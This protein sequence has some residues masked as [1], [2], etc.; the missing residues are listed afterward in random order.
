MTNV[1]KEEIR[2]LLESE[3]FDYTFLEYDTFEDLGDSEFN[4][5]VKN[6]VKATEKIK[7]FLDMEY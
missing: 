3:G 2:N 7:A 1:E 4:K 5:L 6:Y